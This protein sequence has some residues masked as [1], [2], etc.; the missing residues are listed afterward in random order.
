MELRYSLS[1]GK[2][3]C[4][5]FPLSIS[6]RMIQRIL[7]KKHTQNYCFASVELWQLTKREKFW[8]L[9]LVY[10]LHVVQD[11]E[12][13]ARGNEG[14]GEPIQITGAGGLE[15]VWVNTKPN[16]EFCQSTLLWGTPKY[17]SSGPE[18][19]SLAIVKALYLCRLKGVKVE[20][21]SHTCTVLCSNLPVICVLFGTHRGACGESG[22]SFTLEALSQKRETRAL[23]IF[24]NW[25][26]YLSTC[27]G[28]YLL[29]IC[30]F[31][32][33]VQLNLHVAKLVYKC[34]LISLKTPPHPALTLGLYLGQTH[35]CCLRIPWKCSSLF[36]KD[37]WGE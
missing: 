18:L 25:L 35:E 20:G 36:P 13:K 10:V 14:W 12:V 31:L 8:V 6:F 16:K 2:F 1:S 7:Q 4:F 21:L 9:T 27:G 19:L 29:E 30:L 15:R 37:P 11:P 5:C 22:G 3:D 33:T 23:A 24:P 28:K 32:L 34:I 26:P 17:F